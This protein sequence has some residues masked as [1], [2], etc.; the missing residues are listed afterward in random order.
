MEHTSCTCSH[1]HDPTLL[2]HLSC[3]HSLQDKPP[4]QL[5][6][7]PPP[8][9]IYLI[10]L[11]TS[12]L[13]HEGLFQSNKAPQAV[14]SISQDLDSSHPRYQNSCFCKTCPEKFGHSHRNGST[15][16]PTSPSVTC[17]A[18]SLTGQHSQSLGSGMTITLSGFSSLSDIVRF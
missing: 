9:N 1:H 2:P 17:L 13:S 16:N 11:G 14:R 5:E 8:G 18:D 10:S 15:C 7:L 3:S 12:S 4:H 6:E